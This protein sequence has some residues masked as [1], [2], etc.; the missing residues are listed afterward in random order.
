[1]RSQRAEHRARDVRNLTR[2][3]KDY[4]PPSVDQST[5]DWAYDRANDGRYGCPS[6]ETQKRRVEKAILWM[7]NHQDKDMRAN[8]SL[9]MFRKRD[10]NDA[11]GTMAVDTE[12]LHVNPAF[13]SGGVPVA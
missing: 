13:T 6:I 5:N 9:F 7:I 4:R 12:T 8:G 1:M 11:I 2:L 10:Y 3:D